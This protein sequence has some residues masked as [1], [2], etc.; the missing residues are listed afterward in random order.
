M[1]FLITR[2]LTHGGDLPS[3]FQLTNAR[4]RTP[5]SVY[6]KDVEQV[7]D[8]IL[9]APHSVVS[10]LISRPFAS[11]DDVEKGGGEWGGEGGQGY[12]C[13]YKCGYCGQKF[14]D[15]V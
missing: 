9:G 3:P 15:E 5:D 1:Y 12:K 13:D 6:Q 14:A 7:R 11:A 10:L 4:A 2:Q 8:L